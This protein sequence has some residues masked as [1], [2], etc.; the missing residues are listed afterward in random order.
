LNVTTNLAWSRHRQTPSLSQVI[1]IHFTRE[2]CWCF[3][4]GAPTR[5]YASRGARWSDWN[6][7]CSASG[8]N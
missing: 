5:G 8:D 2:V 1:D 4:P 7:P 6:S 3:G